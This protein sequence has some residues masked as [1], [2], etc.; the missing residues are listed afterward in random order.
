METK[1][2]KRGNAMSATGTFSKKCTKP[3]V[4][5]LKTFFMEY[6]ERVN[7]ISAAGAVYVKNVQEIKYGA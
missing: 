3:H 1:K 4:F 7:N 2:L 5:L 6:H